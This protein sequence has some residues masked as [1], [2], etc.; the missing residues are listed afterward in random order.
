MFWRNTCQVPL[1]QRQRSLSNLNRLENFQLGVQTDRRAL[2]TVSSAAQVSSTRTSSL[3]KSPIQHPKT[4]KLKGKVQFVKGGLAIPE[5][6]VAECLQALDNVKKLF[7]FLLRKEFCVNSRQIYLSEPSNSSAN[8]L[9]GTTTTDH[10]LNFHQLLEYLQSPTSLKE[11][12]K[13]L[14]KQSLT[15][16]FAVSRIIRE[17]EKDLL[18]PLRDRVAW[19]LS[20]SEYEKKPE[21]IAV[22]RVIINLCLCFQQSLLARKVFFKNVSARSFMSLSWSMILNQL[23]D[24]NAQVAYE[25]VLMMLQKGVSPSAQNETGTLIDVLSAKIKPLTNMEKISPT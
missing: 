25:D 11:L 21:S 6:E 5:S 2:A 13:I 7:I 12:S 10:G 23:A 17:N 19:I 8:L 16:K 1:I 9:A 20:K 18:K 24:E 3:S 22:Y 14:K 15:R 4:V